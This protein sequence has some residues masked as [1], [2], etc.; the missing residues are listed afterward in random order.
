MTPI[1]T[2]SI[3]HDQ[4]PSGTP[5]KPAGLQDAPKPDEDRLGGVVS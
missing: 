2:T 5:L 3:R 4:I 1:L